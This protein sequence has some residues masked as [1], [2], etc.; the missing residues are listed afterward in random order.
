MSFELNWLV[1]GISLD[2]L[3]EDELKVTI[4]SGMRAVCVCGACCCCRLNS[5]CWCWF[6][7]RMREL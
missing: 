4:T 1:S 2:K 5:L 7:R 6:C 3:V